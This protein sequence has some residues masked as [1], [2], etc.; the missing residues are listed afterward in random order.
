MTIN[1]WRALRKEIKRRDRDAEPAILAPPEAF[2][3]E[4]PDK[5][6]LERFHSRHDPSQLG[7]HSRAVH[8]RLSSSCAGWRTRPT[9]PEF[10][11]ALRTTD[12]T[13]RQRQLIHTWLQEATRE[14]F[15]Y[16][17]AEGVYTW[18]QLAGAI[19]AA[20]HHRSPRCADINTLIPR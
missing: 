8:A 4:K 18:H 3:N 17:W 19:H 9:A 13:P 6:I 7:R 1:E 10:Y 16:A 14:D 12:P 5:D 20:Q 15:L 2:S 11:D